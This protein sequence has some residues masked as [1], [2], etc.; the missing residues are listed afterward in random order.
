MTLNTGMKRDGPE[1]R[2]LG[3]RIS[4]YINEVDTVFS[5]ENGLKKKYET[6]FISCS[7]NAGDVHIGC[8]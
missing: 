6:S 8:V 4:E 1:K 3:N 2:D 5:N 7:W